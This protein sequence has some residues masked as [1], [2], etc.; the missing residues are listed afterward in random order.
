MGPEVIPL[1]P[2]LQ[3]VRSAGRAVHVGS[4]A[5]RLSAGV[6]E[7]LESF[8]RPSGA[9]VRQ[10]SRPR[11]IM[12]SNILMGSRGRSARITDNWLS[13]GCQLTSHG[14]IRTPRELGRK[15]G[16]EDT[17]SPKRDRTRLRPQRSWALPYSGVYGRTWPRRR[18]SFL[19]GHS[20]W[21]G[22]VRSR[23]KHRRDP[24]HKDKAHPERRVPNPS[25]RHSS[26]RDR[27]T[28]SHFLTR[29]GHG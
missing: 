12:S 5:S 23:N 17:P 25:K 6:A 16:C 3:L 8:H 18:F 4:I 10:D 1:P 29:S 2:S 26:A 19:H 15:L 24:R 28:Q 22:D 14:H 9:L 27:P 21:R 11:R 13:K 20:S 7:S